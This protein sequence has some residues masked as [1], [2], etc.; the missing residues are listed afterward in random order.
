MF[1]VAFLPATGMR[2]KEVRLARVQDVDTKRWRV[3]V[4]HPKG[5]DSLAAD[6]YA[7]SCPPAVRPSQTS[8]RSG[9]SSSGARPAKP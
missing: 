3:L 5:E 8:W 4:V 6:S 9:R 7:P 2:R 1:L